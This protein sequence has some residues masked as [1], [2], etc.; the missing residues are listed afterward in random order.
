MEKPYLKLK[1]K[2]EIQYN[3]DHKS[4][5]EF[6]IEGKDL[7]QLLHKLSN[8]VLNMS[9]EKTRDVLQLILENQKKRIS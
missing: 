9:L 2:L 5:K 1:G 3:K 4:T 8:N 7:N 6:E